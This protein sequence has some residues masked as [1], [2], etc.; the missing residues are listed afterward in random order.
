MRI[1]ADLGCGDVEDDGVE[2]WSPTVT[3][4]EEEVCA[5]CEEEEPEDT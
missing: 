5:D 1:L 2:V 3:E 4:S